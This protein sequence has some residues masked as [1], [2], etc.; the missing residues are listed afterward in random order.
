MQV[1]YAR[2]LRPSQFGGL[3][4]REM[5]WGSAGTLAPTASAG[6]KMREH[7]GNNTAQ[8]PRKTVLQDRR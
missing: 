5:H 6:R 4:G 1:V 2:G 3:A 8:K 7:L